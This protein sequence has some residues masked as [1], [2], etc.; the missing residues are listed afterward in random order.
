[1]ASIRT[2]P[3]GSYE[4]LYRDPNG[5]QR[6]KSF[7]RKTD[8]T[9]FVKSVD[10]DKARGEYQDPRLTRSTVGQVA[11]EWHATLDVKPKTHASYT[12]H[13][14]TWVMP[15]FA[16]TRVDDVTP[17]MVRA[18]GKAVIDAGRSPA[19]RNGAIAVLRL[20][21]GFAVEQR[22]IRVN[23]A[24]RLGLSHAGQPEMH[25]L[26]PGEVKELATKIQ[27][28]LSAKR[29]ERYERVPDLGLLVTFGAYTGLRAGEQY[30]LK[31]KNVDLERGRVTVIDNLTEVGGVLHFG[32]TKTGKTRSVAMPP[33]LTE[34]IRCHIDGLDREE[35][36]F[37]AAGGGPMRHTNYR[38]L[39]F[40]PA[41]VAA[42]LPVGVRVH[43]LRHT[44]A[45]WLIRL[46]VHPKGIME[47]L[48]HSSITMT[49][50]TYGHLFPGWDEKQA[51]G[52]QTLYED[53]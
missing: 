2:R 7:R 36:V 50:N 31:V 37:A 35:L 13:L 8:A 3:N 43:D 18:F 30:G 11:T 17:A 25:F 22:I 1:V 48:G 33:F 40:K 38:N 5:R 52:L 10:T 46:G 45:S 16:T 28:P 34:R 27:E 21:L 39:H 49:L 23:P 41:V 26:T 15:Y 20:V 6:S 42:G 12:G 14:T 47:Q 44:C 29:Y 53:E 51:Q 4:V 24:A 32:T 19:T 9:G